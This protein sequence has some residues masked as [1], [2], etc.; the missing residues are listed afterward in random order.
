MTVKQIFKTMTAGAFAAGLIAAAV[1]YLSAVNVTGRVPSGAVLT[2][3]RFPV[4]DGRSGEAFTFAFYSDPQ[5][6]DYVHSRICDAILRARPLFVVCGG[7][8][9]HDPD[10]L[11]QW[12]GFLE[13]SWKIR[14]SLPWL[15]VRGNHDRGSL[16]RTDLDW[17]EGRTWYSFDIRHAHFTVVDMEEGFGPETP[18]GRWLIRDLERASSRP[19]TIVFHHK[20]VVSSGRY[21]A[22]G[23]TEPLELLHPLFVRNGVDLT[24]CGHEHFYERLQKDG[25]TYVVAAGAGG[26][27]RP[28]AK[29]HENSLVFAG[30]H[31]YCLVTVCAAHMSVVALDPEG[32]VIDQFTVLPRD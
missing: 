9:V 23:Y 18:Q 12:R 19:F 7:D 6:N 10:D 14:R 29:P 17:P 5:S 8:F 4:D 16:F 28:A 32:K 27:T 3:N 22:G 25:M 30:R 24:F 11:E 13:S 2:G 21:F 31:H 1:A 20:A 26:F 15:P